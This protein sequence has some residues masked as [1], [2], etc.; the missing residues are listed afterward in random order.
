MKVSLKS[1]DVQDL[2]PPTRSAEAS[3]LSCA[4]IC[5][6]GTKHRICGRLLLRL[7]LLLL[8]WLLLTERSWSLT[9]RY[10]VRVKN[11]GDARYAE[12]RTSGLAEST[13]LTKRRS[14]R[15]S[16]LLCWPV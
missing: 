12:L 14:T 3:R 4:R 8:L 15:L 13:C 11:K 9:E 5:A 7:L 1:I 10:P 6:K 2:E 16:L